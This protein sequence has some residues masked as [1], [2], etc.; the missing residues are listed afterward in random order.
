MLKSVVWLDLEE[1]PYSSSAGVSGV[2]GPGGRSLQQQCWSQWCGWT[3]R[4]IPTA[5]VLKSVVWLDLEEDPG[6][7][8]ESN[9][10]LP[11]SG[12]TPYQLE[13]GDEGV[14]GGGTEGV[15]KR[16]GGGGC[17]HQGPVQ[18]RSTVS[19]GGKLG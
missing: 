13:R 10:G 12:W 16:G 7:Q 15:K 17:S 9:P 11:L 5:A 6:S 2:A 18:L 19:Q 8:R 4:K 1:D 14:G 3:W